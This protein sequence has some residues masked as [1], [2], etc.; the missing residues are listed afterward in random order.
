MKTLTTVLETAMTPLY[1]SLLDDFDSIEGRSNYRQEV[2]DFISQYCQCSD[3]V[4]ISQKPNKNGY[5][6]VSTRGTIMISND[7]LTNGLFIWKEVGSFWCTGSNIET[8]EGS[9]LKVKELFNC[10]NCPQLKSLKGAPKKVGMFSCSWCKNLHSLEGG[11]VEVEGGY[12]CSQ[13]DLKNLKGAP[14][15]VGGHF[16]C[17]MNVNLTSIEDAPETCERGFSCSGCKSLKS[18]KGLPKHVSRGTVRVS[19]CGVKFDIKD[20]DWYSSDVNVTDW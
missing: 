18:L 11:P 4:K 20:I 17:G 6:E 9:P 16:D 19:A 8:L 14:K 15:K 1:E 3:S 5:Y 2:A 10:N 13:C 7:K 12:D